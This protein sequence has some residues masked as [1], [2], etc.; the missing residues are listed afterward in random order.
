MIKTSVLINNYNNGPYLREG[1]ESVLAQTQP[2]D[3]VIVYDDGSTDDSLAVLRSFGTRI[4]LIEG[5]R[6]ARPSRAAQANAIYEAF[7]R[8][9]GDLIFLLDGDDRF[10][11]RKIA[12]YTKAYLNAPGT[13]LIQSPLQQIDATGTPLGNNF[14]TL[15]HQEDYLAQ[16]IGPTT[17]I[18]TIR[19]ARWP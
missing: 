13:S 18:S 14:Q 2:A 6:T 19:R 5:A 9:T 1:V 10:H 8:S 11:P 15:K 7:R 12:E 4:I 17:L 3:E 16:P